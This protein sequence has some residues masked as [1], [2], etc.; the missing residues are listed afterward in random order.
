MRPKNEAHTVSERGRTVRTRLDYGLG[1][2][3]RGGLTD[4]SSER[5]EASILVPD[6]VSHCLTNDRVGVVDGKRVG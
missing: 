5:D 6:E 1:S 2:A 3:E 4:A